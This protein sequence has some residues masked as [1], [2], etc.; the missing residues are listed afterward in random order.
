MADD[1]GRRLANGMTMDYVMENCVS[2]TSTREFMNN[3]RGSGELTAHAAPL[4]T[5]CV[6]LRWQRYWEPRCVIA[7]RACDDPSTRFHELKLAYRRRIDTLRRAS[8]GWPTVTRDDLDSPL[9]LG[10]EF[11]RALSLAIERRRCRMNRRK[12]E[13]KKYDRKRISA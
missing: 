5:R 11:D 3:L 8:I 7:S 12:G 6:V 1:E 4:G 10:V 2:N 9:A 13:G